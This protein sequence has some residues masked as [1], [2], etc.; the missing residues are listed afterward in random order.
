MANLAARVFLAALLPV[1]L[2]ALLPASL[3]GQGGVLE[4]RLVSPALVEAEPGEI[5]TFAFRVANRAETEEEFG[6]RLLLPPG[7]RLVT[8]LFE[9]VLGPGRETTRLVTLQVSRTAPAGNYALDYT[10]TGRRD[11]GLRDAAVIRLAVRPVYDLTLV[12]E[13]RGPEQVVAGEP[14]TFR[15][16]LLNRGNADLSVA[17][18]AVLPAGGQVTVSPASFALPGG[19]SRLLE[20]TA[21]ADPA[22]HR[23]RRHHLRLDAHTDIEVA[24]RPVSARLSVPVEV[25][26]L[27]SGEDMYWRYPLEFTTRLGGDG[28]DHALQFGL[29]GAGYLDEQGRRRL[30]FFLQAPDRQ[31]LGVLGRRDEYWARYGEPG[32]TVK[33]GD[34]GYGLSPLTS[35]FRYGRGLGVDLHPPDRRLGAGLYHVQDRWRLQTRKDTG[36]YLSFSPLPRAAL[37]LNLLNQEYDPWQDEPSAREKLVSL[38]GDFTLGEKDL[39][40]AEIGRSES[41]RPQD[42]ADSAWRLAYSGET[43]AD[44]RYS[45]S[46]R[47]A[48]PDYAG[49]YTDSALYTATVSFPLAK[50]TRSTRGHFTY[51]RYERNLDLLPE[52]GAAPREDLYQG[53]VS[54]R[55]PKRWQ[56]RL[57]YDFYQ[58][59]D[60]Q[61]VPDYEI[62]EHGLRLGLGRS[63]G[64]F[65][66]RAEV[67]RA[68][69]E[70]L[71]TGDDHH[72]W[73]Y[74]LYATYRPRRTLYLSLHGGFGDDESPGESRL[75]RRGRNL[76]G[77][78]YWQASPDLAVSLN[79][80]RYDQDYPD[81]PLRERVER[82]NYAAG[83]RYRLPND[84]R[85]EVNVRRSEG[86]LQEAQTHYFATYTIPFSLP[87]GRR[88]TV[89]AVGG[90]VY[91][92]GEPG[93]PGL[94]D[95][96]VYVDGTA[97]RTDQAGNFIFQTLPPGEYELRVDELS[98]GLDYV[99]AQLSPGKATVTGGE[100]G[101]VR[102]P[103]V[104]A[105]RLAGKVMIVPAGNNHHGSHLNGITPGNGGNGSLVIAG[106]G[107]NGSPDATAGNNH[108]GLG[109]ILV[110][111]SRPDET[112][113]TVSDRQGVFLFERLHPGE[114]DLK[115]YSHNLP[116]HHYLEAATETVAVSPGGE[117]EIIIRVLPRLREIRFVDLGRVGADPEEL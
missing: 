93:E 84:H 99:P 8:P 42:G 92:A 40:E 54:T 88:K 64:P 36:G 107:D 86:N 78:L 48:G 61:A 10:V 47:R 57:D 95:A 58:R 41:D 56:A 9:F 20:I 25:V 65:S 13:G 7:W 87:L 85:L 100:T 102:I 68:W 33:A 69:T 80:S 45:L 67:R 62:R 21:A 109:N 12:L 79:Y 73:N 105:G 98:V 6:E 91:L 81:L 96:V 30:D 14:F 3:Y 101:E 110:E 55:L 37:R 71:L 50:A 75:L 26:P 52:R 24:G 39:L 83:L 4:V 16:R 59:R 94:A 43:A 22:E 38:Q 76:G 35:W 51:S 31:E 72:G 46:G 19:E 18:T 15:A 74:N 97:A 32:F 1:L 66:Y 44:T 53:G 34:Q 108:N 17:M 112:R 11:Y 111:L 2:L 63:A 49:R 103:L 29:Q 114:W 60:G 23:L 82:D 117:E 116:D 104:R 28:D 27:V 5:V 115:I 77:S 113:R 90:R 89:G 106:N 70:N